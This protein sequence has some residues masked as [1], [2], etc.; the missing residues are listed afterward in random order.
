MVHPGMER[1]W[2]PGPS[3]T[4]PSEAFLTSYL[5]GSQAQAPPRAKWKD[6]PERWKPRLLTAVSLQSQSGTLQ[7]PRHN[8]CRVVAF[9]KVGLS[10]TM[11]SHRGCPRET[12][13]LSSNPES[14]LCAFPEGPPLSTLPPGS[15]PSFI[16]HHSGWAHGLGLRYTQC[17]R[18]LSPAVGSANTHCSEQ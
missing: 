11:S 16:L 7:E 2:G 15:S 1:F 14:S 4:P 9:N 8:C 10:P 13:N 5:H 18:L 6:T 17:H 3:L 12:S